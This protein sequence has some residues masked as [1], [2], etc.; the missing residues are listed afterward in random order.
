MKRTILENADKIITITVLLLLTLGI[1]VVGII[2][3]KAITEQDLSNSVVIA[4]GLAGII[5]SYLLL[6][7]MI[8]IKDE[9]LRMDAEEWYENQEM[10]KEIEEN[11]RQVSLQLEKEYNLMN[12]QKETLDTEK[13]E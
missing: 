7:L 3:G 9:L 5:L 6:N 2:I 10:K 13:G 8:N 4:I 1:T 11:C 12:E